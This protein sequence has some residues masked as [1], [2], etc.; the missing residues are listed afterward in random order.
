MYQ[1]TIIQVNQAN[2]QS[3]VIQRSYELPVVVDFWAPW[4]G[5]CRMLGPILEGLAA[6]PNS[7]F[8]LAKVNSDENPGLSTQ[9]NVRGI[10]NVKAFRGGRVVDEFVG[11][12]PEPMVRQFIERLTAGVQDSAATKQT[13]SVDPATRLSQARQL[14]RKGKGCEAKTC[15]QNFPA[16]PEAL[17][18]RTLLPLAQFVCDGGRGSD[19]QAD[20]D[21]LYQ[22]AADSLRR[23]EYSAA[24]YNL[25]AAMR[26]DKSCRSGQAEKVMRGL[27]ELLGDTHNLTQAYRPQMD[28]VA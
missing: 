13:R 1:P 10:P 4:C 17:Q 24:M 7:K 21:Q 9:Y 8:I 20:L 22:Q 15:L 26:Q 12:Q 23:G 16:G 27:F 19:G 2:F 28:A 11:A 6:E 5:P 18:A 3:E 25:L 14:L